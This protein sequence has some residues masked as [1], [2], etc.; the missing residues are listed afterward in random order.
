MVRVCFWEGNNR[1][2]TWMTDIYPCYH[3]QDNIF[4]QIKAG[5]SKVESLPR[6]L[7][8]ITAITHGL[9]QHCYPEPEQI[10]NIDVSVRKVE[11]GLKND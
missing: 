2:L 7:Y 6:T 11:E 8:E 10:A 5:D 4:L 9:L 3:Y 1:L